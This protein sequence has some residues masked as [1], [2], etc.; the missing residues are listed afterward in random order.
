[1]LTSFKL[2]VRYCQ[3][4]YYLQISLICYNLRSFDE[5]SLTLSVHVDTISYKAHAGFEYKEDFSAVALLTCNCV[6][7]PQS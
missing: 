7:G 3:F 5:N 1:M 2:A 6:L 4:T